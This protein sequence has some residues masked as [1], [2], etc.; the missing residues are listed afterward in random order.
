MGIPQHKPRVPGAVHFRPSHNSRQPKVSF[1]KRLRWRLEFW[2][3]VAFEGVLILL[4]AS[5]VAELGAMAGK[6]GWLLIK[7]RRAIVRRNL[8]IALGDKKTLDEIDA[9][10]CEVFLKTGANLL[11]AV[12]S[13]RV[14]EVELRKTIRIE[15]PELIADLGSDGKK[16]AVVVLPHMGNWE[17]L[18][19]MIPGVMPNGHQLG[20]IYRYMKNQAMDRRVL[21]ARSR[22]GMELFEKHSGPLEMAAFIRRG[23]W[24]AVLSDQ[25]V[26][27][28]GEIVPF[29]GRLTSCTPLPAMMARRTDALII[30]ASVKTLTSGR[31]AVKVHRLTTPQVTTAACMKLLEETILESPGDVFWFQDRWRIDKRDPLKLAGRPPR[32]AEAAAWTKPRRALVWLT[33]D[34]VRKITTGLGQSLPTETYGEKDVLHLP[35]TPLGDLAWEYAVPHGADTDWLPRDA[36]IHCYDGQKARRKQ[37]MVNELRRIDE[38]TML[39]LDFIFHLQPNRT[40]AGAARA[41][42]L[43]TLASVAV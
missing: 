24:L 33:T 39:P 13:S 1:A 14:S 10:T 42:C 29:F 30:G 25:R 27:K 37:A 43:V 36:R 16:G 18:S 4:P 15:N 40:L 17:A 11:S 8:R 22:M 12:R 3:Y 7:S 28:A 21:L 20:S 6:L 35:G 41:L 38:S 5:T 31:W 2:I 34:D 9:L 23:G 26:E 19:Q 32:D